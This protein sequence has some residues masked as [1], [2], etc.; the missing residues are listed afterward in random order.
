MLWAFWHVDV[1]IPNNWQEIL[2]REPQSSFPAVLQF[3]KL[4]ITA[5][6][7][8]ITLLLFRFRARIQARYYKQYYVMA[9][10]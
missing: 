2:D 8:D 4:Q 9:S 5:P 6:T 7:S 3:S 1:Y 10:F